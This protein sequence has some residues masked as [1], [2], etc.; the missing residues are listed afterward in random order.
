MHENQTERSADFVSDLEPKQGPVT[1]TLRLLEE[2]RKQQSVIMTTLEPILV[3]VALA[4]EKPEKPAN[5][6]LIVR[7]L[8]EIRDYN[9]MILSRIK[10]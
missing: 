7:H 3:E 9:H 4:E 5:R 10:F 8:E 6:S 2:I 1:H